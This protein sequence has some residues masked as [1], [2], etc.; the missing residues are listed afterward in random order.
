MS[1]ARDI[2]SDAGQNLRTVEFNYIESDGSNEGTREVEPYSF[3]EKDETIYFYG[4]DVAKDGIRSF[5][6]DNLRDVVMTANSY[7]PRWPVEV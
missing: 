2:I 4:F 5:K 6:L 3:K 1:S 7:T